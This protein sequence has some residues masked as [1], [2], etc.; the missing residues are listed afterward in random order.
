MRIFFFEA[1]RGRYSDPVYY[2][3]DEKNIVHN[4]E[5]DMVRIYLM[6]GKSCCIKVSL[7]FMRIVQAV[8]SFVFVFEKFEI[9]DKNI[10]HIRSKIYEHVCSCRL[11]VKKTILA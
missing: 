3:T 7:N 10:K 5:F 2:I 8:C 9:L 1:G 11:Y 4:A 6:P